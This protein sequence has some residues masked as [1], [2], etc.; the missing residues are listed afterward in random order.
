MS[1]LDRRTLVS[2]YD[3]VLSFD[4]DTAETHKATRGDFQE[5]K[6]GERSAIGS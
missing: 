1:S 4:H 5:H 3:I 6:L 2:N